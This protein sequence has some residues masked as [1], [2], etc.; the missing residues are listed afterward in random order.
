[1]RKIVTAEVSHGESEENMT[2]VST[3]RV[4]IMFFVYAGIMVLAWSYLFND[5]F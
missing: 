4:S 1:M 5:L 3:K 2:H